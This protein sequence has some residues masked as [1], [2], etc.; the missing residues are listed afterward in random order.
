MRRLTSTLL[1][2]L[3][4]VGFL[5]LTVAAPLWALAAYG[6]DLAWAEVLGDDYIRRRIAWTAVQAGITCVLTV[7]L[8]V[9]AAWTLARLD[10]RGRSWVLRLL[11]LPFVMPTLVAGI[12]VLSLFGARGLLWPGWQDT[13]Y[14]LVYGN[15]FFNLPVLVRAA[16]QG[17][18]AVPAARLA[19]ARTLG[20][21]AW[22]RFWQVECPV[23]LPWL[24]G[25]ACL[26]FLYCFSGFGLAL[27]LGGT[28]YATAEVEIY[29][30]VTV[31]LDIAQAGVLVWLVLGV[32]ALA[33]TAYAYFGR[34][35]V[36]GRQVAP[37]PLA[38]VDSTAR[39]AMLFF[40]LA[41]LAF[42][43]VLPLAAVAAQ[44][45]R[46][47]ESW[48]VL[49]AE[50][51]RL[52]A[53]NTLRFTAAATAAALLLGASH[54]ALARRLPWIRG[55][56]FLP[57]MVSPV[58]VAFGMLLLYPEWTAS[59]PL[60][61]AAYAL[62]AYPFVTKDLLAAWDALPP[63]YAAAA[64][65][66]GASRFQTAFFVTVPLLLPALRRGLTLAAATCIGEFAAT[67]FLSRPEWLTLTTLVYQY[68]GA[69]GA[70]NHDRAAVLTAALMLLASLVFVLLDAAEKRETAR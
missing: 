61:I 68:L 11:M 62:L 15:V 69:A 10:F 49:W 26:V 45:A 55:I 2:A 53:W 21:D 34:A 48:Q 67:L 64:R 60:L 41:V 35:S 31:E 63:Q 52:A 28:D 25:G 7:L 3:I 27:L 6:G 32:T 19:A 36:S 16:Y 17:L 12:G 18:R 8:G 24:A 33:G 51:T 65:S 47:G 58:C 42:F 14:L 5:V 44:A 59:L 50:D 37:Q 43:C 4:P 70:D 9:P 30:L 39:R 13:P 1:L 54:A 20:A 29:R 22:R 66:M 40:S 46:S 57:F 38:A 56:T 23:L